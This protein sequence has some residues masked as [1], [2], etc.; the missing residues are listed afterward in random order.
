MSVSINHHYIPQCLMSRWQHNAP[1]GSKKLHVHRVMRDGTLVLETR[2]KATKS[3][4]Y[5]PRLYS[6]ISDIEQHDVFESY[7]FKKV[8]SILGDL[9]IQL[10]DGENTLSQ[11][12]KES[13]FYSLYSLKYRSPHHFKWLRFA[14]G[15]AMFE[16]FPGDEGRARLMIEM[17]PIWSRKGWDMSLLHSLHPFEIT[18]AVMLDSFISE[19]MRLKHPMEKEFVHI[20][21]NP[22]GPEFLLPD[23]PFFDS[24]SH[25]EF[26]G[27][28][29][30]MSVLSPFDILVVCDADIAPAFR[31]MSRK[32]LTKMWNSFALSSTIERL[33]S[34]TTE[35]HSH[36]SRNW[37]GPLTFNDV[38]MELP[39][40]KI[41]SLS[42]LVT[43]EGERGGIDL[44]ENHFL[45]DAE[46]LKHRME[47]GQYGKVEEARDPRGA[48]AFSLSPIFGYREKPTK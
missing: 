4:N 26:R 28:D 21:I 39:D 13:L 34:K 19:F 36:I 33:I 14:C 35:L 44:H 45:R 32:E 12:Q 5:K 41:I 2:A 30:W 1:D 17:G 29:M 25:E 11:D 48:M 10:C 3:I 6:T 38:G 37:D 47:N 46:N 23:Y 18:L 7:H 42:D 43:G 40:G 22:Y 15:N 8:D 9:L 27:R 24:L 31:H 16:H 20:R